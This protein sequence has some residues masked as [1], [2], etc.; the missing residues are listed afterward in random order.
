M[1]DPQKARAR[2]EPSRGEKW[3][4]ELGRGMEERNEVEGEGK[5]EG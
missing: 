5:E 3:R 4:R 2:I 1:K